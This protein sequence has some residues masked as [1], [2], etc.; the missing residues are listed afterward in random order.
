MS[1]PPA[2]LKHYGVEGVLFCGLWPLV[3][4]PRRVETLE[5]YKSWTNSLL[6]GSKSWSI[7]S[8]LWRVKSRCTYGAVC[9]LL[10]RNQRSSV[11]NWVITPFSLSLMESL[12]SCLC[13]STLHLFGS[14]TTGVGSSMQGAR[15]ASEIVSPSDEANWSWSPDMVAPWELEPDVVDDL[16]LIDWA[17]PDPKAIA[18]LDPVGD[19]FLNYK[20]PRLVSRSMCSLHQT[21]R[22]WLRRGSYSGGYSWWLGRMPPTILY[23]EEHS[24]ALLYFGVFIDQPIRRGNLLGFAPLSVEYFLFLEPFYLWR[25]C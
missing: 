4:I 15:A 20:H 6:Y 14:S 10:V 11:T 3:Y 19:P 13:L 17:N 23:L 18:E 5:E 16:D 22:H 12:N 21:R 1:C 9:K 2:S 8:Y 25:N 7:Q 24:W